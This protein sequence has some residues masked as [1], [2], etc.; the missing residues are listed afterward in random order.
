MS[1]STV[2]SRANFE[3]LNHETINAPLELC[4]V[5]FAGRLVEHQDFIIGLCPS[6][7]LSKACG[8]AL[9]DLAAMF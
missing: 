1:K 2:E 5:H 9:K 7:C 6:Q 4:T 8:L 3:L